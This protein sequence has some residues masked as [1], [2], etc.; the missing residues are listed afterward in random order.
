MAGGEWEHRT[1]QAKASLPVATSQAAHARWRGFRALI[2]VG[3]CFWG[4]ERTNGRH[5]DSTLR[6]A[7]KMGS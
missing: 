3:V 7:G 4:E 6:L 2:G 1:P 5:M